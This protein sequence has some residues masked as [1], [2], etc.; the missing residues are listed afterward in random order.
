M[1]TEWVPCPICA[2]SA[3]SV[4][5][6]RDRYRM[7]VQTCQCRRC[8][9]TMT[10]P[11][12]TAESLEQF[13]QDEYRR[14]YRKVGHPSHRLIARY[15]LDRRAEYTAAFLSSEGV[16]RNGV[17]VLDV[18]C[19]EGSLLKAI[20]GRVPEMVA[21]GI[22]PNESYAK[23]ARNWARAE[24]LRDLKA[25]DSRACGFDVIVANHVL[26]H[27]RDPADF[28]A[29]L[30]RLV[31]PAGVLYIDVPDPTRYTSIAS[32]HIAHLYHFTPTALARLAAAT[33]FHIAKGTAHEPPAHP[34]SFRLL[35]T[36]APV[37][38]PD[39]TRDWEPDAHANVVR[40][41]IRRLAR[42]APVFFLRRSRLGRAIVAGPAGVWRALTA[43]PEPIDDL[44]SDGQED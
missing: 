2:G 4:L 28:L 34:P 25:L 3:F 10:N 23:F 7:G 41:R 26:E 1:I 30:R 8:G 31:N 21:T 9:L 20:R 42:R 5:T 17:A 35:L 29:Q 24:V 32:L 38:L 14:R 19:A 40:S 11:M 39:Q 22:E 36:P 37:R 6:R 33:G 13:Y 44:Q 15:Q 27:V 16:L 18:G 12:P 43:R